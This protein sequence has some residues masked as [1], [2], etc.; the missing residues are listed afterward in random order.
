MSKSVKVR[1]NVHTDG[2]VPQEYGVMDED[3]AKR[4]ASIGHVSIVK[5]AKEA[6]KSSSSPTPDD[7]PASESSE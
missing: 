5:E 1:A 4:L 3:R 7:A 6:K 2:L